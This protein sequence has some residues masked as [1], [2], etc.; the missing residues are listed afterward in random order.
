MSNSELFSHFELDYEIP[1]LD[2]G[3]HTMCQKQYPTAWRLL[4]DQYRRAHEDG[5][6][7]RCL[8]RAAAL[9]PR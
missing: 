8:Q 7:E 2:A 6:R 3:W 4:A 1:T 9:D 5:A